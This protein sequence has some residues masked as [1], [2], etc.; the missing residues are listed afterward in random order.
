MK[1]GTLIDIQL[2]EKSVWITYRNDVRDE[3]EISFINL[4]NNVGYDLILNQTLNNE[5][6]DEI[7]LLKDL[8][9]KETY[10]K[11]IFEPYR[12]SKSTICKAL[13]VSFKKNRLKFIL[14]VIH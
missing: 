3:Y 8:D 1:N 12:F 14:G 4:L 13:S 6:D 10:L 9:Q 11:Y 7:V 5:K 2:N